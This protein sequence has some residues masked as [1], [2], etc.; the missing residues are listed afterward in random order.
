MI[1]INYYFTDYLIFLLTHTQCALICF[2][3]LLYRFVT[4]EC[5]RCRGR[6]IKIV[7]SFTARGTVDHIVLH[8]LH[9]QSQ[10]ETHTHTRTS[11]IAY[12]LVMENMHFMNCTRQTELERFIWAVSKRRLADLVC[13]NAPFSMCMLIAQLL[14]SFHSYGMA[15][16]VQKSLA[17][18]RHTHTRTHFALN[19]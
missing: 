5:T 18:T 3:L 12:S 6:K 15:F 2:S 13:R 16:C 17:D 9:R 19:A 7:V 1:R 11:L 14:T 10:K 4:I 8:V